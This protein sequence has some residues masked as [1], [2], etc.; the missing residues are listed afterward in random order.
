MFLFLQKRHKNDAYSQSVSFRSC[1][2]DNILFLN[3][4]KSCRL[5]KNVWIKMSDL[6]WQPV[7]W[8]KFRAIL[9]T[10][11]PSILCCL[12]TI[13]F[14]VNHKIPLENIHN[15][16]F[17]EMEY[18]FAIFDEKIYQLKCFLLHSIFNRS[19]DW[20]SSIHFISQTRKNTSK[21]SFNHVREH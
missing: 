3:S 15:K 18:I 21:M 19:L 10:K 17:N 7:M 2:V 11:E 1:I 20:L 14:L 5:L 12:K 9:L 6:I 13:P 4:K 8:F 16:Y